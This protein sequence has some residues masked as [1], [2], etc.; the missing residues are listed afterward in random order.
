MVLK[1]LYYYSA[2]AIG[3]PWAFREHSHKDSQ[4]SWDWRWCLSLWYHEVCTIYCSFS[5]F[6]NTCRT[7][8]LYENI[9]SD[10][11]NRHAPVIT[12]TITARPHAPCIGTVIFFVKQKGILGDGSGLEIPQI[13]KC[14]SKFLRPYWIKQDHMNSFEDCNTRQLFQKFNK[15]SSSLT[16]K[17]LPSKNTASDLYSWQISLCSSFLRKSKI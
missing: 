6:S 9:I 14:T 16:A 12:Q 8:G 2:G 5:R 17:V 4:V 7:V 3:L 13:L 15:L 11:L 10:L 1:L